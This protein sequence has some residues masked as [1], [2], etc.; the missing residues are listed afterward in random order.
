[1]TPQHV[2]SQLLQSETKY[3]QNLDL[4]KKIIVTSY[5]GRLQINGLP[6]DNTIPLANYLFDDERIMFDFTRLSDSK[7]EI[8]NKWLFDSHPDKTSAYFSSASINEVR[9]YSAEV[10]LNW[11]GRLINWIKR[12]SVDYWKIN[13]LDFSLNYQLLGI[14]ACHGEHGLLIGF[15]Q[16]LAPPTG[17][18]YKN[19]N[20]ENSESIG[21][22]KRIFVTDKL[23]DLLMGLNLKTVNFE[24][25][26]KSEHPHSISVVDQDLRFNEMENYRKIQQFIAQKPWYV[27][28]WIWIKSFFYEPEEVEEKKREPDKELKLLFQNESVE[29]YQRKQSNKILVTERRPDIDNL[30]LCG[31]GSKIYAHVGVWKALNE[32][33]IKPRKFA[34]SSAGAIMSLLCYLNYSAD[35]ITEIFKNFKQEHLVNFDMDRHG[36]SDPHSLKTALDFLIAKRL[37]QVCNQYQIP[38]PQGK[39]TFSVLEQMRQKYPE[40]G[41]GTELIVTA[42]NKKL[43]KTRFFSLSHSPHME[44]SEAVKVS[45]SYPVLFRPTLIDGEE[46]NDG[47]V[48]NNLPTGAFSDDHS[49]LLESEYGNNLKVLAVQFDSGTERRIIDQVMEEVYRENWILNWIYGGLTGVSD[50]VSGWVK[51][52]L[53]LRKYG[54]QAIVIDVGN[55]TS[56]NFTVEEQVRNNMIN[57]GYDATKNYLTAR[58]AVKESKYENKE[59]LHATFESFSD[60]LAYCC[61]RGNEYWFNIVKDILAHSTLPNKTSLMKHSLTLQEIYFKPESS[62]T[63]VSKENEKFSSQPTFFGNQINRSSNPRTFSNNHLVLLALY[64]VII[65]LMPEMAIHEEDQEHLENARHSITLN[66]PLKC[67]NYFSAISNETHILLYIFIQLLKVFKEKQER[68][69]Y[70]LFELMGDILHRHDDLL[71]NEFYGNWNFNLKDCVNILE[72]FNNNN[73]NG[74]IKLLKNLR[75]KKSQL[76]PVVSIM[77]QGEDSNENGDRHYFSLGSKLS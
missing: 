76:N 71:H 7:K 74:T 35:E 2:I 46:Y 66:D 62:K 39:I 21:N 26:C 65:K 38:Y 58:Y 40:C 15:E 55:V 14:E 48:L 25:I 51:D 37:N 13:D 12:V 73:L 61:Y 10:T 22:T 75:H 16:F 69:L 70:D 67:I 27:R 30:V 43:R 77:S 68:Q 23:V 52:R 49:T 72:S 4:L 1:M 32:A 56:T 9:G 29:I 8:F 11:W 53:S 41:F 42:T 63:S 28:L 18:K 17:S 59:L 19:P 64:P 20:N 33:G 6:P 54:G 36:L 50:P 5:F 60:L 3:P 44:V 34:G 45:A 31:G 47:G 57:S 24:T